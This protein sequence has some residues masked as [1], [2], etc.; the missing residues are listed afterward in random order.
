MDQRAPPLR[1]WA[2]NRDAPRCGG[3]DL[4]DTKG[5]NAARP[6]DLPADLSHGR[7]ETG[8]G[9]GPVSR[10]QEKIPLQG[11]DRTANSVHIATALTGRLGRRDGREAQSTRGG[12]RAAPFLCCRARG[13]GWSHEGSREAEEAP[14]EGRAEVAEGEAQRETREEARQHLHRVELV[15]RRGSLLPLQ[16]L[17][18]RQDHDGAE[19]DGSPG[20]G[21]RAR[22][23]RERDP[24]P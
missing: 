7:L 16:P 6:D 3:G 10:R 8:P 21:R 11:E 24:N 23:F 12:R 22:L 4:G 13:V 1:Y 17:A 2:C 15:R 5:L 18:D 20:E 19:D 9:G 14:E